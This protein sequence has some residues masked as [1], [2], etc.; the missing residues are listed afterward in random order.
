M[1]LFERPER[2]SVLKSTGLDEGVLVWRG[3]RHHLV[4]MTASEHLE[5]EWW[6]PRPLDRDYVVAEIADGR[7]FWLF[8]D[9]Q[10]ETF[11]HGVFD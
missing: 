1:A 10:G 11:V 2:A 7:R 5:A 3:Q 6:S 4:T 8:F 9:P